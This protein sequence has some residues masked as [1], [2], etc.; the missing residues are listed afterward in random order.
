MHPIAVHFPQT[1]LVFLLQALILNLF[2]P[3]FYPDVLLGT[4]KFTAV[5]FP[6]A[7]LGAYV[8]GLVDGKLRF[9]SVT[10]PILIKKIVYSS[11]M[12]VASVFTPFLVWN[13]IENL[14]NKLILLVCG[15]IALVCA[16]VLGHAGKR[17]MNIG[18][19][20]AVKIWGWKI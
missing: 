3:N 11:I 9:K 19:G 20:G 14:N 18:M 5:I 16:I 7:V 2:F 4:A 15:S 10:T 8:T 1:M 12:F 6:F 17:L 13:G